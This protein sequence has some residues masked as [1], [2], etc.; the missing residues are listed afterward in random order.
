MPI[1]ACEMLMVIWPVVGLKLTPAK[2]MEKLAKDWEVLKP[3]IM[4]ACKKL[5]LPVFDGQ[6]LT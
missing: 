2:V 4:T 5:E 1:V 3:D 6:P